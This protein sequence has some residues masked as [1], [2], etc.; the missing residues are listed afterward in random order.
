[1]KRFKFRLQS[2][3]DQRT[4]LER[5]AIQS[6]AQAQQAQAEAESTL[7]DLQALKQDLIEGLMTLRLAGCIDPREQVIYQDYIRQVRADIERQEQILAAL[8]QIAEGFREALV[9]ASQNKLAVDKLRQNKL[10]AHNQEVL[11]LEQNE[12]DEI[13]ST[14][15]QFQKA[16]ETVA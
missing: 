2:V 7:M 9:D 4:R 14:R 3:L 6:Y 15:H 13:A 10:V 5:Q 16:T 11:R 1:M 8:G 12:T